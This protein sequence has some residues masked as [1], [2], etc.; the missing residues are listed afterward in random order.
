METETRERPIPEHSRNFKERSVSYHENRHV[1]DHGFPDR[2]RNFGGLGRHVNERNHAY[3][4]RGYPERISSRGRSFTDRFRYTDTDR[5]DRGNGFVRRNSDQHFSHR[6]YSDVDREYLERDRC[7]DSSERRHFGEDGGRIRRMDFDSESRTT[8][9]TYDSRRKRSFKDGDRENNQKFRLKSRSHNR[10]YPE[11]LSQSSS[12][13]Q[14]QEAGVQ[15]MTNVTSTSSLH[16]VSNL[17]TTVR[18]YQ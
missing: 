17:F 16:S 12:T 6:N 8:T 18:D 3:S 13:I 7:M 4:E 9:D 2:H 1:N 5:L 11:D 14:N 15:Q 10:I